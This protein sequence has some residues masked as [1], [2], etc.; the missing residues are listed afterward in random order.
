MGLPFLT[1]AAQA[2][3]AGVARENSRQLDDFRRVGVRYQYDDVSDVDPWQDLSLEYA[4]RLPFGTV[5][6]AVNA[7][8]RYGKNGAQLE[9]QAYPRLTRRSYVFLDLA[10]SSSKEVYLPLR[11]VAEPY[12]NFANGWELSAG[13]H[14][15]QTA[16]PDV[17]SYTG[18]LA[19]YFGN[20]WISARPSFTR[21]PDNNSYAWGMTGRRYFGD[22]YDYAAVTV[23]RSVGVDPE[24]RD[25]STFTRLP[26]LG[27]FAVNLERRQPLGRSHARATYGIGYHK[28]QIAPGRN[29]LHRSATLGLEWYVR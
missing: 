17:Y 29:R 25:P 21:A 15:V 5:I 16:G 19:K 24:A 27:G 2:P 12:Y 18:T 20:Y 10:A 7:A 1:V 6:S 9:L 13:A 23:N 28:E 14:Y 3:L 8:R 22:R 26:K 4:Q 11:V